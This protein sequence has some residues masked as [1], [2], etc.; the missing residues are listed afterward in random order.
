MGNSCRCKCTRLTT[1]EQCT[2]ID[3]VQNH[4]APVFVDGL[5]KVIESEIQFCLTDP[6][7][8]DSILNRIEERAK[9]S[10]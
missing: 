3:F 5:R 7:F 8:I 2:I 9:G 4:V 1:E 10:S 6:K